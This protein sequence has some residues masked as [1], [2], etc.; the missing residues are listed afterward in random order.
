MRWLLER[1]RRLPCTLRGHHNVLHFERD[2]LSLCC[3]WCGHR[4][5]GWSLGEGSAYASSPVHELSPV[6]PPDR[7]RALAIL[8]QSDGSAFAPQV[9]RAD[10]FD[11]GSAARGPRAL[12]EDRKSR[13][14]RLA[15]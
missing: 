8:D 13:P 12:G 14:M 11:D 6:R 7:A 1:L 5:Q 9:A 2:R 4:T 3:L 10:R 15:S